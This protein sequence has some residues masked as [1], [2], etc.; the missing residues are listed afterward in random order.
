LKILPLALQRELV[1]KL[2]LP[3]AQAREPGWVLKLASPQEPA[4]PLAQ[5]WLPEP[6]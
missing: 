3:L 2:A 6:P 5:A 4:L 1:W